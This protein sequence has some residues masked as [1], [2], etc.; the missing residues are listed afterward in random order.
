MQ[1]TIKYEPVE[2]RH[3]ASTNAIIQA[4]QTLASNPTDPT[5]APGWFTLE[6]KYA[7]TARSVAKE[8]GIKVRV[9]VLETGCRVRLKLKDE[10]DDPNQITMG[11]VLNPAPITTQDSPAPDDEGLDFNK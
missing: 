9:E 1:I 7:V 11:E 10:D 4:L 8:L 3:R 2:K 6:R 5:G